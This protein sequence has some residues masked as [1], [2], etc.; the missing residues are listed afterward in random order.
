MRLIDRSNKEL[1]VGDTVIHAST[2][3]VG[4]I[5]GLLEPTDQNPIGVAKIIWTGESHSTEVVPAV[6]NA[7]FK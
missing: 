2:Y 5:E 4:K 1:K 6:I 3:L 7:S